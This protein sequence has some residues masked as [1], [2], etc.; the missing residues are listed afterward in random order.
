MPDQIINLIASSLGIVFLFWFFFF[1]YRQY[2]LDVFRHHLF[3]ARDRL[4]E[5][6]KAGDLSFDDRAYGMTRTMINGLLKSADTLSLATMLMC[7]ATNGY[8]RHQDV[9]DWFDNR[10]A[11]A[12]DALTPRGRAAVR[13]ALAEVHFCILSHIAHISVVLSPFVHLF[14][15]G[16]LLTGRR[17]HGWA[18]QLAEAKR[19]T[20]HSNALSGPI[21]AWEREAHSLGSFKEPAVPLAA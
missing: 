18:E 13:V 11:R 15:L 7:W 10:F 17:S 3:A 5:R 20:E 6:A 19:R 4:F 12:Q 2:R 14:K 1:A 16:L 21:G 8:W 9:D